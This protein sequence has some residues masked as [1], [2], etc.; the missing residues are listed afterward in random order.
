MTH[1]LSDLASIQMGPVSKL[2]SGDA[3]GPARR[4]VCPIEVNRFQED[5]HRH[6]QLQDWSLLT[7]KSKAA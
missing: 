2:S 3:E 5:Q 6:R 7:A 1:F 4:P